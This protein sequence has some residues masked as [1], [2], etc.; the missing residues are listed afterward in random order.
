MYFILYIFCILL[1]ELFLLIRI[2]CF[3]ALFEVKQSLNI[4]SLFISSISFLF[5]VIYGLV[6]ICGLYFSCNS[7]FI[8]R[9]MSN[10]LV[11]FDHSIVYSKSVWYEI[12]ILFIRCS[13]VWLR[14]NILTSITYVCCFLLKYD[15]QRVCFDIRIFIYIW[16]HM[17]ENMIIK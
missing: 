15:E 17:T 11:S 10:L 4:L 3:E 14:L 2:H 9:I 1:M 12:L 16:A 6:L 7:C 13:L 8:S 5:S